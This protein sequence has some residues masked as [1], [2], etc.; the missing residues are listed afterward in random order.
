MEQKQNMFTRLFFHYIF[1]LHVEKIVW[2]WD[3]RLSKNVISLPLGSLQLLIRIKYLVFTVANDLNTDSVNIL[4]NYTLKVCNQHAYKLVNLLIVN[5]L[6]KEVR[7]CFSIQTH[8][9]SYKIVHAREPK[10]NRPN[11]LMEVNS[12]WSFWLPEFR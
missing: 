11:S 12:Q 8:D 1:P 10:G 3:Y 9:R 2:A 6:V 4:T 5:V 7:Q